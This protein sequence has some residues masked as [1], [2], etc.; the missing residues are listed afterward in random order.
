[1]LLV[2]PLA[3]ALAGFMYWHRAALFGL[4]LTVVVL[5]VRRYRWN[6]ISFLPGIA[7]GI[8]L[9]FFPVHFVDFGPRNL[10]PSPPTYDYI[11]VLNSTLFIPIYAYAYL[12]PTWWSRIWRLLVA[13]YLSCIF[14]SIS[15]DPLHWTLHIM[16]SFI[17]GFLPF[18]FFW[19]FA[20]WLTDPR[21]IREHTKNPQEER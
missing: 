3:A 19:L 9:G 8:G 1:M 20:M 15:L 17:F 5:F 18:S 7:L 16:D 4:L 21:F 14:R 13:G 11:T 6:W 12:K 10:Y 2:G